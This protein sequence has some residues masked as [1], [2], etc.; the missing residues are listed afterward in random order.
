MSTFTPAQREAGL[1]SSGERVGE[2]LLR[3]V[4]AAVSN[5]MRKPLFVPGVGSIHIE[6]LRIDNDTGYA[7]DSSMQ[8]LH[9][10]ESRLAEEFNKNRVVHLH[11]LD[12]MTGGLMVLISTRRWK[13]GHARR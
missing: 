5:E 4:N 3:Y 8:S 7:A 12:D 11:S 9:S 1:Q 13:Y 2:H 6:P 10:L